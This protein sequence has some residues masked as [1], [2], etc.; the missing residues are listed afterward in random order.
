MSRA[1]PTANSPQQRASTLAAR[2]G[3]A[4][5]PLRLRAVVESL[6]QPSVLRFP[7][8]SR[9]ATILGES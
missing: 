6:W 3:P 9:E 7:A 8:L 2:Y 1:S 4:A 5:L